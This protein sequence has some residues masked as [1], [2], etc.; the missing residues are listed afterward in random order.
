MSAMGL[1]SELFDVVDVGLADVRQFCQFPSGHASLHL[2]SSLTTFFL[3]AG[4]WWPRLLLKLGSS[5]KTIRFDNSCSI[6]LTPMPPKKP[7]EF[8]LVGQRI[9]DTE[10]LTAMRVQGLFPCA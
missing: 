10:N 5:S 8:L 7:L 6:L 9:F 4:L 1:L 2:L 3:T